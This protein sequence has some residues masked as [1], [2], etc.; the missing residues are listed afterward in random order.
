MS[1]AE[2]P[3]PAGP[4]RPP[5]RRRGGR[6]GRFTAA[7]TIPT[8][9][10]TPD[11]LLE[12]RPAS[13]APPE[14]TA[15]H[16]AQSNAN[17]GRTPRR[18]GFGRGV[19]RGGAQI[20]PL[21]NGQR[22][23]GGQLTSLAPSSRD[24]SLAGDAPE[25]VP[26]RPIDTRTRHRPQAH[27]QRR[28]SKSQAPDIPTR[29]HEDIT[30]G[31]YECGIC[32]NE[33]L[34]NSKVWSCKTCWSVLHLSCV[35]KW[36]MNE[37]ATH[38]QRAAENDELPPPRQWRCPGCNLPK[39]EL[40]D[41]YTCW[42]AKEI[43]P[44]SEPGLP[45]HSCGQTCAKKR[46]G[47]CPHPCDMI[48]HAG[49]C[50]PCRAMGPSLPCFCGKEATARPC[51]NTNYEQGWS[52]QQICGDILPCGEHTCE[53][54]CHEGLCG[55]CDVLIESRCYCGSIEKALPCSEREDERQSQLEDDTWMGSFNCGS[56]CRRPFDCG[57]S[58][59]FCEQ[60]CHV[61]ES[62]L[63]HCPLSPDVVTHCPCGKTSLSVLLPEP[64][65]SCSDKIPHCQ[66]KCQKLLP[67]L[68]LCQQIC[69]EG[70]CRPCLERIEIICRCGRTT[71]KSICHQGQD[72]PPSCMRICRA[73][74]NCGRHECGERCCP[75]EKRASERQ[76]SK[77]KHRALNAPPVIEE[78]EA[79]HICT[80]EC[81]K[82][83][84]CGT[85]NC[86]DL[87]HKG[88]CRSCLD[89]IFHEISCACGR[90]K[91]MP[92]QPCG[93]RPPKCNY[94]C[95]RRQDCGHPPV[96][97]TCHED[98][99]R[100]PPCPYLVE[101]QCICGKRT[102]KNQRCHFTEVRCGLPCGK[103]LKCGI[104]FCKKECH[105]PGQ[106]EDATSPC[107]QSCGRKKTVCEHDCSDPCHAP[108]PCK[109]IN[110][111]QAKTFITCECQHQKQEVK[112]LA[113]KTGDG[114]SKKTLACNDECLRLQRNAKLAAAL[115]IDPATHTSDH[116]P[117]S[118]QTLEM[119]RDNTK[120]CQQYEREFRVF[121]KD[122]T[123][124][125]LRFKPM[126]AEQRAFIHALAEDFGLDSESQDPEPNR[127]VCI[128]KTPR[129][130]SEPMKTL[131][132][133]V[134]VKPA[135]LG[136]IASGSQGLVR[137]VEPYNAFLLSGPRFGLTIDELNA[138][139]RPIFTTSELDFDISFLPSGDVVLQSLSS[140]SW[141]QNIEST[142]QAL[143]PALTKKI[144]SPIDKLASAVT[145]CAVDG[146][147]NVLRR[148]DESGGGGWNQVLKGRIG[149]KAP[150]KENLGA[151]SSFTVLGKAAQQ[152][153]I[154][155]EVVEEAP[156]D[157]EKEVEGWD[158]Q[159]EVV[160]G[161]KANLG[162]A[163]A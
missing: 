125:R 128:F 85:H 154:K 120:F 96:Q 108:Y 163:A 74:L 80:R 103:K 65:T 16:A 97:H 71:S 123:E 8:P 6:G 78:M 116:I 124:K 146:N 37:V 40:P 106:C 138:T 18:G 29:T 140:G 54:N 159:G 17:R 90:T 36:S 160:E 38:Q 143:K 110:P 64:R 28:M 98:D 10:Q 129:F 86:T 59:H 51:L 121:A 149:V 139:V 75:G 56:E 111:C 151:K 77:R 156:E 42:C 100:C 84:K 48:C 63:G 119:F 72:E 31:Q 162:E 3:V 30:N 50:P 44:R 134:R 104:H 7:A 20:Q 34:L 58:N 43:E 9:V 33:V 127:H 147:L 69:H 79:E 89:A 66:E 15:A 49:P 46:A 145:L 126:K 2:V 57:N 161:A 5:R 26:G 82:P 153:K 87:C 73:T 67:C 23:F 60:T 35:K 115:D 13:V 91:L 155:K 1:S 131:A 52:C 93:T 101:K 92:P 136:P 94:P 118:A 132:Q 142:L 25:F 19:R 76:A 158:T 39:N 88:P 55:S 117:Y 112:C 133:C 157:W 99:E 27:R 130:V 137:N 122:E 95:N 109:E 68:H 70:E 135:E 45:P 12:L 105:R 22:V 81:G 41:R 114:N 107:T 4:S 14:T 61:Q 21:I 152:K 113:S 32:T 24:G 53:R 47:S 62:T 144:K 11:T 141:R 83:L 148:E 102:L 150:Q